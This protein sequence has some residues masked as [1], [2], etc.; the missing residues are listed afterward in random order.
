[1]YYRSDL[2]ENLLRIYYNLCFFETGQREFICKALY[3]ILEDSRNYENEHVANI[4]LGILS[5]IA[6]LK[7]VWKSL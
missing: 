6:R 3:T 7:G 1:M 4:T 5:N 2:R